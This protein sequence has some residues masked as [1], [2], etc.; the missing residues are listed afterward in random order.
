MFLCVEPMMGKIS[1][2]ADKIRVSEGDLNRRVLE[3]DLE[4]IAKLI[5]EDWDKFVG[6]SADAQSSL[7]ALCDWYRR[8]AGNATYRVLVEDFLSK[9]K[10]EIAEHVCRMAKVSCNVLPARMV[11]Y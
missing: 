4:P 10:T 11:S 5:P 3:I 8:E 6:L 1:L 9:D 7:I 2:I